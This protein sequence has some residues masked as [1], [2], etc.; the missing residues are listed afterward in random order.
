VY[1][2]R[3]TRLMNMKIMRITAGRDFFN[4]TSENGEWVGMQ[5]L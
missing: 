2:I 1:L 5:R 4:T 3:K